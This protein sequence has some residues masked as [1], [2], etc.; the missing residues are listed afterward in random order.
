MDHLDRYALI[1]RRLDEHQQFDSQEEG[2]ASA[3]NEQGEISHFIVRGRQGAF[4][5]H[6]CYWQQNA[7]VSQCDWSTSHSELHTLRQHAAREL[8]ELEL[9][10]YVDE[11]ELPL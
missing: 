5:F 7:L 8:G 11:V 3:D 2:I 1:I 10:D 9:D 6:R 4:E